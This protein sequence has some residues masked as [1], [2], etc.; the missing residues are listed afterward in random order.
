[1]ITIDALPCSPRAAPAARAN[2]ACQS[3][4]SCVTRALLRAAFNSDLSVSEETK[5]WGVWPTRIRVMD[6]A[7]ERPLIRSVIALRA[8]SKREGDISV[9]FI[10]ADASSKTITDPVATTGTRSAGLARAKT[11][12]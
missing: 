2:A 9:A 1:M 4:D 5:V 11:S 12:A 7:E 8:C 10:E 6:E 3:A